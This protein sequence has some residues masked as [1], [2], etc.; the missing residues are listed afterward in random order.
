M[1]FSCLILFFLDIWQKYILLFTN[2]I[3][4]ALLEARLPHQD[5]SNF[6]ESV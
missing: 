3:D 6:D 4:L 1:V 2:V 5:I